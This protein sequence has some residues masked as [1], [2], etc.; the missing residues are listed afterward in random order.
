MERPGPGRRGR[1]RGIQGSARAGCC[2][3]LAPVPGA[4]PRR[5]KKRAQRL[6][7]GQEEP[8]QAGR[9]R[10]AGACWSARSGLAVGA[11]PRAAQPREVPA[12]LSGGKRGLAAV[13]HLTAQSV[14]SG[15]PKSGGEWEICNMLPAVAAPSACPLRA[16]HEAAAA[17]AH[18]FAGRVNVLLLAAC[19]GEHTKT[20]IS[21]QALGAPRNA[22]RWPTSAADALRHSQRQRGCEHQSRMKRPQAA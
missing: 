14:A 7:R 9:V 22:E 5:Q 16:S 1:R 8:A 11:G 6:A 12:S 21:V 18:L 2:L 15:K 20:S 17:G 4:Y 10:A 19:P 3:A 13:P